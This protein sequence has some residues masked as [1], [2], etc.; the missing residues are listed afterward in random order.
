[1]RQRQHEKLP[2]G[3]LQKIVECQ[4]TFA[5]KGP[6]AALALGQQL[7]QPAVSGA[8][9]RIDQNVRRAVDENEPRSDQKSWLVLD[10]GIFEFLVSP[11]D[12]GE[13]GVVGDADRRKAENCCLLNIGLRVRAAAQ[14]REIRGDSDFRIK[15]RRH[16]NN[17]CMNQFG[18]TGLS[19]CCSTSSNS[20]SR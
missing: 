4:M 19:S 12:A 16:A 20:P 6:L 17:P 14:E 10:L 11:H 5:L 8:V 13:C 15:L 3:K 2:F 9:A 1:M 7:T 18:N